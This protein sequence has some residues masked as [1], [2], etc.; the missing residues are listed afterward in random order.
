[1]RKAGS[2]EKIY[3]IGFIGVGNYKSR[4][5]SNHTKEYDT[6]CAM[7]QRCYD[8]KLHLRHPSYKE[9]EVIQ[10]WHNFQNFAKWFGENY[11]E[12][13]QLDK[14]L[15]VKDNK[16]YSPKTCCFVPQEINLALIKPMNKRELPLGVY[17]HHNRFVTHIKVGKISTY[18]GIF[19]TIIEA[20]QCYKR[21]KEQ[22]LIDLAI[23][24][25][26]TISSDTYTALLN[27]KI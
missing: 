13:Y 25:K 14:D 27:Y 20:V 11:I 24:Y 8:D 18:K 12:T 7:L 21:E 5:R 1:M 19:S 2:T 9:C 6:W 15:L 10:E 4:N 22:Q 23:R 16:V 26:N 17:K 3:G